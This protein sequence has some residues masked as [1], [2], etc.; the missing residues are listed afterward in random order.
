VVVAFDSPVVL[1]RG[2]SSELTQKSRQPIQ[3]ISLLSSPMTP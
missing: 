1:P 2:D 3:N